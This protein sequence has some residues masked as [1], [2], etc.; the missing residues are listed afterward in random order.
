MG[1]V[2]IESFRRSIHLLPNG[3]HVYL[4]QTSHFMRCCPSEPALSCLTSYFIRHR[5][6]RHI[7]S[8]ILPFP[9]KS[10]SGSKAKKSTPLHTN[11]KVDA[12]DKTD[13][14]KWSRRDRPKAIDI[15]KLGISM[16]IVQKSLFIWYSLI[17]EGTCN[18]YHKEQSTGQEWFLGGAKVDCL[19]A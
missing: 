8:L 15:Y 3:K 7:P 9:A 4:T 13:R 16:N 18:S 10:I 1:N 12:K 6:V 11:P 19:Q 5:K 17:S 2:E 14:P